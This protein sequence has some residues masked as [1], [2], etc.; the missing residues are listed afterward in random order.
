MTK[1]TDDL[2]RAVGELTADVRNLRGSVDKLAATVERLTN[3]EQRQAGVAWLIRAAY[4]GA[5][6]LLGGAGAKLIH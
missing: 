3:R 4:G 2:Q 5:C 1:A 6:A